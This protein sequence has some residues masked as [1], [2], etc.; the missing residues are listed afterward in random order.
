M[1]YQLRTGSLRQVIKAQQESIIDY[2]VIAKCDQRAVKLNALGNPPFNGRHCFAFGDILAKAKP[3]AAAK[4][5]IHSYSD[6]TVFGSAVGTD[7]LVDIPHY[8]GRIVDFCMGGEDARAI[9]VN[10]DPETFA[11]ALYALP[12][13]CIAGV[14]NLPG[15]RL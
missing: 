5:P 3:S 14:A 15:K 11:A 13:L 1:V 12:S 7:P 2:R 9:P 4:F 6:K 10:V 8:A